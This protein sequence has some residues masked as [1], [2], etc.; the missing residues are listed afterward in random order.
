MNSFESA[1][2]DRLQTKMDEAVR[3]KLEDITNGGDL[4]GEAASTGMMHAKSVGYFLAMRDVSA[5]LAEVE[6]DLL[7][8]TRE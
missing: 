4:T 2:A 8:R 6:R 7:G 5:M 1:V 3:S